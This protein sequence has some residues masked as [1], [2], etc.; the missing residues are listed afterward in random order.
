MKLRIAFYFLAEMT[1]NCL[2]LLFIFVCFKTE[3]HSYTMPETCTVGNCTRA[4]FA[5]C[6]CC[7]QNICSRHL[8]EHKNLLNAELNPLGDQFNS[9]ND[10]LN[11]LNVNQ[12]IA[13]PR[14]KL[15]QW[16]DDCYKKI[17]DIFKE[18]CSELEQNAT[19]KLNKL[20]KETVRLRTTFFEHIQNQDITRPIIDSLKSTVRDLEQLMNKIEKVSFTIKIEP[21]VLDDSVIDI[22]DINK[23]YINFLN[24]EPAFRKMKQPEMSCVPLASN[25]H[26]LLLHQTPNLCLIN[27]ELDIVKRTAWN[28]D[29]I[30][31]MCWSATLNQFIVIN[32]NSVF[33]IDKKLNA[34]R[35]V[36]TGQNLVLYS[37][38]CS[39]RSLF[40]STHGLASSVLEYNLSP[41]ID[42]VKIWKS[43]D[44]CQGK[45]WINDMSY[46]NGSIAVV[47]KNPSLKIY[48]M[49][50]K[51]P[52]TF[53]RLWQLELHIENVGKNALACCSLAADGWLVIDPDNHQL[54]YITMEGVMEA[55]RAY[56][57]TLWC[58]NLL[59]SNILAI[60]T[61]N[62]V[63]FHKL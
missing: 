17:D 24:L 37:S 40:L 46:N 52:H 27:K 55:K 22:I 57:E 4:S 30:Q 56:N 44:T 6:H 19:E 42:F 14:E 47:I 26:F 25:D 50:L 38:T 62:G 23:Y 54:L 60:T 7:A 63:N 11:A 1:Y 5:L 35:K 10:R 21:L 39:D 41:T 16:R 49:E 43:P 61:S 12:M 51:N 9:I 29:K 32:E 15:E 58:A 28:N 53:H 31:S 13:D 2:F 34:I 59:G 3:F 36:P 18:K 48:R 20:E 33:L 45:E 8:D